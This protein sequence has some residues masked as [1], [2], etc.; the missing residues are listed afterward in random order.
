MTTDNKYILNLAWCRVKWLKASRGSISELQSVACH[1]GPH[2]DTCQPCHAIT[3]VEGCYSIYLP[4]RME[5]WVDLGVWL[6]C[7]PICFTYLQF[8]VDPSISQMTATWL[9]VKPTTT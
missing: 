8:A 3:P 5:G 9:E 1:T 6:Y 2:S 7:R 4:G